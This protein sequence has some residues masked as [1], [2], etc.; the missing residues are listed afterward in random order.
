MYHVSC[1]MYHVSCIMYSLR[2]TAVPVPVCCLLL[3]NIQ[4]AVYSMLVYCMHL[5]IDTDS[6]PQAKNYQF[7]RLVYKFGSVFRLWKVQW[8]MDGLVFVIGFWLISFWRTAS[9]LDQTQLQFQPYQYE[10]SQHCLCCQ[11]A[12]VSTFLCH[13]EII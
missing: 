2:C 13:L 12:A 6:T 9:F 4:Y 8:L 5:E 11:T 7:N 3:H 10:S 1:I